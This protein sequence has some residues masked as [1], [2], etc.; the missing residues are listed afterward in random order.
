MQVNNQVN[1]SNNYTNEPKVLDNNKKQQEQAAVSANSA[2]TQSPAHEA[3]ADKLR[4]SVGPSSTSKPLPANTID[5][6]QGIFEKFNPTRLVDDLRSASGGDRDKLLLN[7]KSEIDNMSEKELRT[8]RDHLGQQMAAPD[9]TDDPFLGLLLNAVN[10]ELDSRSATILR[11]RPFPTP[12]PS[13]MPPTWEPKPW[14]QPG[15]GRLEPKFPNTFP[16]MVHMP[17]Q[18]YDQLSDE[19]KGQI[20]G[21]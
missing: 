6:I 9:N 7:F 4:Q 15:G 12:M 19:E 11:P 10:A 3:Q 8:L 2:N 14:P 18:I 20:F 21:K 5:S 17:K 13:P 1:A 16:D